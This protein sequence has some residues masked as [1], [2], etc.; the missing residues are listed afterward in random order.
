M[1][2]R[3]A[4]V[5]AMLLLLVLLADAEP[6]TPPLPRLLE[7]GYSARM[8]SGGGATD[9]RAATRVWIESFVHK[10]GQD[11]SAETSIFDKVSGI[12]DAFESKTLDLVVLPAAEYVELVSHTDAVPTFI[13]IV[14][15]SPY[16]NYVLLAGPE[17]ETL[18]DLQGGRLLMEHRG[19]SRVPRLWLAEALQGAGLPPI[20][21]L[22]SEVVSVD[23][24][25]QAVLPVFFR[26]ERACVVSLSAFR[27]MVE[28]NPQ[29]GRQLHVLATSP[30]YA[31]SILCA[32]PDFIERYDE[33]VSPTIGSLHED[34]EGRQLLTL[35]HVDSLT[36]FRPDY[37]IGIQQHLG[38]EVGS[39]V[40]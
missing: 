35:F 40:P 34:A 18:E 31:N 14:H 36:R 21:Q 10:L 28:L 11:V 6:P 23:K 26:Q 13:S 8:L 30:D 22:L 27:T 4:G 33:L 39:N 19:S 32:R 12:A 2:R 20:D 5:A 25:A 16:M 7:V 9:A 15:G 1:R 17:T 38:L 29:L 3:V 24:T 37:L